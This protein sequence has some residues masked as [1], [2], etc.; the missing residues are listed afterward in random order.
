MQRRELENTSTNLDFYPSLKILARILKVILEKNSIAKTNLSQESNV[1]YVKV[2]KY[3]GW[4]EDKRLVEFVI[5]EGKAHVMLSQKG[6]EFTTS[7]S[8]L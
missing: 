5:K 3:L 1:N 2:L 8:L 7:I 6:R 4:L